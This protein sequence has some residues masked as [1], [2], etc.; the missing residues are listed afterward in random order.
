MK[1]GRL[2][3]LVVLLLTLTACE[4]GGIYTGKLV[5]G[6]ALLVP[7]GA[8]ESMSVL[9][10]DGS[11]TVSEGAVLHGDLYQVLGETRIDGTVDGNVVHLSGY[12][13]LGPRARITGDLQTGGGRISG[14]LEE[15]V[16]GE[17]NRS[18][19]EVPFSPEWLAV[20][21][22]RQASWMLAQTVLITLL[23]LLLATIRPR[24]LGHIRAAVKQHWLVA[25]AMG[26]L[27]GLVG[28]SLLVQMVFTIL[29]I[30]VSLLGLILLGLAIG[31]GWAAFGLQLGEWLAGRLRLH[32]ALPLRAAAGTVVF[33][34]GVN[35]LSFLPAFGG[36]LSFSTALIGLGAVFLTRF[37][38]RR[39]VPEPG[40]E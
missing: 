19:V 2:I 27:V 17:I 34:L 21:L 1:L 33:M 7:P 35:L 16:A 18:A 20:S 8:D 12:L 36:L 13:A 30:P 3:L 15:V 37:G 29:L 39:F 32:W 4:S 10:L 26:A 23:A 24:Q 22:G 6:G 14:Q 40:Q 9:L 38:A 5:A 31:V 28:L 11:V 25:L